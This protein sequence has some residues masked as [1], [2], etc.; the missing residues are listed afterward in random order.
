L[1]RHSYNKNWILLQNSAD[2]PVTKEFQQ[3]PRDKNIH[4]KVV[5][6]KKE[7]KYALINE[8][9]PEQTTSIITP[10]EQ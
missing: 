8:P 6:I 4:L 10:E 5:K 7:E 2:T 9:P 3:Q 1:A